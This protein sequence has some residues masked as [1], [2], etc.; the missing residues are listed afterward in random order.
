MCIPPPKEVPKL[1]Y[2]FSCVSQW[3]VLLSL[4]SLSLCA[5]AIR[6][7]SAFFKFQLGMKKYVEYVIPRSSYCLFIHF[8]MIKHFLSC[9]YSYPYWCV[10]DLHHIL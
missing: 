10:D 8:G 5:K 9:G 6:A 2:A 7:R 1:V 4:L 3:T